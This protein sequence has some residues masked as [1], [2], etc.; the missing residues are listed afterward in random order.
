MPKMVPLTRWHTTGGESTEFVNPVHVTRLCEGALLAITGARTTLVYFSRD[1]GRAPD[2]FI[3]VVG[4]LED[5]AA[6]I[7]EGMNDA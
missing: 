4:P 6:R 1:A 2:S 3:R 5:I 7:D